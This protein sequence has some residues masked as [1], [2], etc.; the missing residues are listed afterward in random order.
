MH[1]YLRWENP[2][3]LNLLWLLPLAIGLYVYAARARRRAL[4]AI[5]TSS[6]L[7]RIAPSAIRRKRRLRA[8]LITAGLG[9]LVIAAARPQFG[10]TVKRV[11]QR[12]VDVIFAVDV[13]D[14]M[15][16]RDVSPDRLAAARRTL[17]GIVGRM[18]GDRV[19]IVAFAGDAL[20]Y[21]PLTTDYEA[22]RI[23]TDALDTKTVGTPGT[24][25]ASAIE[26]AHEAF[27][28]AEHLHRHLVIL[29]DGEDHGGGAET[30]TRQA[31]EDGIT[32]HVVSIGG[33][34]GEPIPEIGLDGT[35]TGHRRGPDGDIALSR[36]DHDMARELAEIGGGTFATVS[37]EGLPV[38]QIVAAL[39]REEGRLVGT[40][41]FQHYEERYQLPLAAAILLIAAAAIIGD[42]GRQHA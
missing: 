7:E 19:G 17:S 32:I 23:F 28:A 36:P 35:I 9:L 22:V 37:G 10:T 25:I 26:V 31:A 27:E 42:R 34:E 18:R 30:A 39:H 3:A 16:A 15:L 2:A 38:E 21:C 40:W 33:T 14:S 29:T 11:E 8:A 4:Q 41:Q 20:I 12:G 1:Q 24:A 13:S 5:A 6:A